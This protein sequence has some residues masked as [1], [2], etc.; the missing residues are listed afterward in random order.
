VGRLGGIGVTDVCG[1]LGC[2]RDPAVVV[3][4]DRWNA[5]RTVCEAHT[6]EAR[7]RFGAEVIQGV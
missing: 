2:G 7:R 5:E 4:A 1:C 6:R 3:E